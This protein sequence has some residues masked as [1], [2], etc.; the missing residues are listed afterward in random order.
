[1]RRP[2]P[3]RVC[4]GIDCDAMDSSAFDTYAFH[5]TGM[6]PIGMHTIGMDTCGFVAGVAGAA[7]NALRRQDR[8]PAAVRSSRD[9]PQARGGQANDGEDALLR[10]SRARPFVAR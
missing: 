8:M 6:E 3:R 1:M 2:P 4:S 7:R 10:P 5:W 9:R